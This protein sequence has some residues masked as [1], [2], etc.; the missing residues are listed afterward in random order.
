M[1]RISSLKKVS[2][3]LI[4]IPFIA[5]TL[6]FI[7]YL[8]GQFFPVNL[9]GRAIPEPKILLPL[10]IKVCINDYRY[11]SCKLYGAGIIGNIIVLTVL[12]SIYVILVKKTKYNQKYCLL[13]S[14]LIAFLP[15]IFI[16]LIMLL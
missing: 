16:F 14:G 2:I 6:F 5:I 12:S 4:P 9:T 10:P 1:F 11:N 3:Y 7:N 13:F 15:I 8:F